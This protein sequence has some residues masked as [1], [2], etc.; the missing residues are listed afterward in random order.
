MYTRQRGNKPQFLYMIRVMVLC[1]HG[2]TSAYA[3]V[4]ENEGKKKGV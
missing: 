4:Y 2:E 3:R 1:V